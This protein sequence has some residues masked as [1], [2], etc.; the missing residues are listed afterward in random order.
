MAMS[1]VE[2]FKFKLHSIAIEI[3]FTGNF[4][5]HLY[6]SPRICF[7]IIFVKIVEAIATQISAKYI[8]LVIVCHRAM[9]ATKYKYIRSNIIHLI[10]SLTFL[11]RGNLK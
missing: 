1:I 5:L 9:I 11:H 8:D 4:A 6:L 7:Y 3:P 10:L 2:L